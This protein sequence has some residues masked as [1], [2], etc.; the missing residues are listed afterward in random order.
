M[1]SAAQIAAKRLNAQQGAKAATPRSP[2]R[3]PPAELG[4]T[5]PQP[6]RGQSR[7]NRELGKQSQFIE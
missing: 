6:P 7:E 4:E 2:L 3:H 1:A 5:T